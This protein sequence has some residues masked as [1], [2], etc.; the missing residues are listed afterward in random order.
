MTPYTEAELLAE[1][2][3]YFAE[4]EASG[5]SGAV[6]PRVC[7]HFFPLDS[8]SENI[9]LPA[10]PKALAELDPEALITVIGDPVGIELWQLLE[11]EEVRIADQ[12]R[13][14]HATAVRCSAVYGGW[15]YEP[16]R[17]ETNVR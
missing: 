3:A 17:S 6:H 11:P 4:L 5:R 13:I 15:S 10:L 16:A 9:Y 2:A 12:I 14:F 7:H 8:A 1:S